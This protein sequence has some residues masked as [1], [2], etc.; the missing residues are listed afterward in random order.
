MK[1]EKAMYLVI[2]D[3]KDGP[4][5]PEVE[6]KRMDVGTVARDVRDGQYNDILAIIELNPATQIC[7]D[8]THEFKDLIGSSD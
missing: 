8:V 7:R 4:Y 2:S 3:H 5:V 1:F 6:V